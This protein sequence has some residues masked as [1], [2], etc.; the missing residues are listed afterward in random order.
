MDVN[1]VMDFG[2][3]NV[4]SKHS[5]YSNWDRLYSQMTFEKAWIPFSLQ[6]WLK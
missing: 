4:I 1:G 2:K 5:S 6:I 3:E